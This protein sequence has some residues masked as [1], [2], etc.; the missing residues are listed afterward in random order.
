[1]SLKDEIREKLGKTPKQQSSTPQIKTIV[2][3]IEVS[4][5]IKDIFRNIHENADKVWGFDN[6]TGKE[7]GKPKYKNVWRDWTRF[8]EWFEREII[9]D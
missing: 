7:K 8:K 1:M 5:E 2:K 6:T 9:K 4:E 3:K